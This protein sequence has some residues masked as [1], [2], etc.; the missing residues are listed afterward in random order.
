MKN[1]YSIGET[2]KINNVSIQALRLYDRIG[3]LKPYYINKDNGYRYYSIDQFI[4][5]D[6][7]KY[8]KKFG[9]PLHELKTTLSLGNMQEIMGKVRSYQ[10]SLDEQIQTLI[11]AKEKFSKLAEAIEYGLAAIQNQAPYLRE[12]EKRTIIQ[13][14]N[15][16]EVIDFEVSGRLVEIETSRSGLDLAFESGYF[17]DI[18]ALINDGEETYTSAYLVINEDNETSHPLLS[19]EYIVSSIPR[20]EFICITYNKQNK[21]RKIKQLQEY[22]KDQNIEEIKLIVACELYDDFNNPS[23]EIQ[24]LQRQ[25]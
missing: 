2:A 17:V 3:L 5:I 13:L 18:P 16:Q 11:K 12:S 22:L 15:Q 8:A 4:Y 1:I 21:E 23:K 9:I 20:G 6:I 14:K 24:V 10:H 19:S 25:R 7:I